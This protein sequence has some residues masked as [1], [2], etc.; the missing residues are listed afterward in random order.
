MSSDAHHTRSIQRRIIIA[1]LVIT[2]LCLLVAVPLVIDDDLRLDLA[3]RTGLA[4]GEDAEQ[5]A[6][7]ND[8]ATLIVLPLDFGDG[9]GRERYRYQAAFIGRPV[10][11]GI[12]LSQVETNDTM[13]LPITELEHVAANADGTTV[14]FRG[15][16]IDG[17]GDQAI[18]LDTDG[19]TTETL[20]DPAATPEEEGDWEIPVWARV[21]GYCDRLS[22]GGTFVA[23]FNR[24]DAASYL[25]GDWQVDVQVYGDYEN[26]EPVYRGA[27]FLPFLGFA[28]DDSYLYFQNELGIWRIE[29][30]ESLLEQR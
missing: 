4:P 21:T 11:G 16:A 28:H 29:L 7:A 6:D 8:G 23:C 18:V 1:L 22:P 24:P 20:D 9:G 30:P 19:L 17:G 14:L 10:D 3:H 13:T 27:G 15:P 26:T 25:A 12:E 5:I 2:G